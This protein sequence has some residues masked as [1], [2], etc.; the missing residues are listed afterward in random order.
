MQHSQAMPGAPVVSI[1]DILAHFFNCTVG[2][3]SRLRYAGLKDS[4]SQRRLLE[5][6]K[7]MLRR[8]L[9]QA[10]LAMLYQ[11]PVGYSGEKKSMVLLRNIIFCFDL[12]LKSR[13]RCGCC[14]ESVG[15]SVGMC[16]CFVGDNSRIDIISEF[17]LFTRVQSG[18]SD[19]SSDARSL[20]TFA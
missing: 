7:L 2:G 15:K 14:G 17:S 8:R 18:K 5:K 1:C 10:T 9:L 11:V 13:F 19:T 12:P 20:S 4:S 3:G 16:F 6:P